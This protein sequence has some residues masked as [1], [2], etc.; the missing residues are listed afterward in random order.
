MVRMKQANMRK[1]QSL[2]HICHLLQGAGDILAAF[3]PFMPRYALHCTNKMLQARE[4]EA[5]GTGL[6]APLGHPAPYLG[7]VEG[8]GDSSSL[9]Q[10]HL[11]PTPCRLNWTEAAGNYRLCHVLK[12]VQLCL[13]CSRCL[14]CLT[15]SSVRTLLYDSRSL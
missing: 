3:S 7:A 13:Q 9:S 8:H 6:T 10:H 11:H 5:Y 2:T 1:C 4:A 12:S 14:R 15:T